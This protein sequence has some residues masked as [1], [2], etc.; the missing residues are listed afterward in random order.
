MDR[1]DILSHTA[2]VG[3][4]AHGSSLSDVFANAAFAMFDLMYD[5]ND[6]VPSHTVA[7]AVSHTD[8]NELMV[9]WLAELLFISEAREVIP[10]AFRVTVGDAET[11]TLTAEV[12]VAPASGAELVGPPVKAVTYHDL[13]IAEDPKGRWHARVIFD[14]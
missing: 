11:A 13:D 4:V 12:D 2:D 8:R 6:R 14:V 5:L 1:Y 3:I 7:V 10:V 9:D